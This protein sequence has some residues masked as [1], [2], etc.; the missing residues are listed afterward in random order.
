M[1]SV[2]WYWGGLFLLLGPMMPRQSSINI[3]DP[4][5]QES[6]DAILSSPRSVGDPVLHQDQAVLDLWIDLLSDL[7]VEAVQKELQDAERAHLSQ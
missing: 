3:K 6:R 2:S 4:G 5:S 1:S 7:I